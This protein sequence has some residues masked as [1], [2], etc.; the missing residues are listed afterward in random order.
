M[1]LMIR[2]GLCLGEEDHRSTLP[3]PS[4]HDKRTHYQHDIPLDLDHLA[5]GVFAMLLLCKVAPFLFPFHPVLL[6]RKSL[7]ED[8]TPRVGSKAP[9]R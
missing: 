8:H 7:C 1:F 2:L 6:G 9:P 5:G 4:H 3:F